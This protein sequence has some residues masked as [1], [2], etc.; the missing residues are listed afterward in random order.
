[1][2]R[3]YM[4]LIALVAACLCGFGTSQDPSLTCLEEVDSKCQGVVAKDDCTLTCKYVSLSSNAGIYMC[5]D[6]N[7]KKVL[8]LS[9]TEANQFTSIVETADIGWC[10]EGSQQNMIFCATVYACDYTCGPANV[11]KSCGPSANG[12]GGGKQ[13]RPKKVDENLICPFDCD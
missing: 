8:Q 10:Q 12:T 3:I 5:V 6:K 11:N 4:S 2:H 1:M 13:I 9:K 7:N